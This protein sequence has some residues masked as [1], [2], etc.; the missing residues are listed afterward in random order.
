MFQIHARYGSCIGLSAPE[1][2]CM[3]D[4][5]LIYATV[6]WP[7]A[8]RYAGGFVAAGCE[9]FAL[10]PDGAPVHAS[11]YV[12]ENYIYRPLAPLRSLR[13]AIGKSS[14]NLI[15]ACDDRAVAHLLRLHQAE[16]KRAPAIAALVARSLGTPE[17][18][19]RVLSRSGSLSELCSLGVRVPETLPVTNEM[20]LDDCVAITGFPA[21]LKS[22]GSWGG[23][24]VVIARTREEA[25]AAYRKL[26]APPA[27]WR[28]L[29]R[30][31]RRN[32]AHFLLAAL[33]PTASA[34]CVQR[35]ITGHQAASAFAADKG[36]ITAAFHYDVLVAQSMT[37]PPSVIRRVDCEEMD[38]ACRAVTKC[39]GLSG[40]HGLDFIRDSSGAVHLI[41]INPRATQGGSLP[42]G[43]GRDLPSAIAASL[44]GQAVGAREAIDKDIVVFFPRE[45]QRD[46]ESPYLKSGFHEVPWDDPGIVSAI[47]GVPP[48]KR[49][50][51]ARPLPTGVPARTPGMEPAE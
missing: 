3:A 9:V 28:S 5:I 46:P 19:G 38:A 45:W 44:V 47:L 27:R 4:R 36:T 49:S 37:G 50:R 40:L 39:F 2:F 20:E 8:A 10:S 18:Y 42:F 7:S 29:A 13:K 11:R 51:A 34:V 15:I 31:I 22:D 6:S 33:K 24:G 35:F 12:V 43:A 30:A 48:K 17:N 32:D 1:R 26:S 14:P 41:E 25:R 23:D 21:V 16:E